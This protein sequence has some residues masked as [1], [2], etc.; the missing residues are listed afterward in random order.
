MIPTVTNSDSI[1]NGMFGNSLLVA[2]LVH[3]LVILTFNFDMLRKFVLSDNF[4]AT[5]DAGYA[6]VPDDL[7]MAATDEVRHRWHQTADGGGRLGIGDNAD[8]QGG[9]TTYAP[10]SFLP[11]TLQAMRPY[12]RRA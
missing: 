10:D 5:Y 1:L 8:A 7:V 3:G 6:A 2:L 11:S 4:K 12:R 9:G